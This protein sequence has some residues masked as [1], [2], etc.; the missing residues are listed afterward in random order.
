MNSSSKPT[1]GV[2]LT[3]VRLD[4]AG[5]GLTL[6]ILPR[7]LAEHTRTTSAGVSAPF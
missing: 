4:V 1:V 5:I 3:I 6:P 7:L 2:L